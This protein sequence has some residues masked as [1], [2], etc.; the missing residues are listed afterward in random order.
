M[1]GMKHSIETKELMSKKHKGVILGKEFGERISKALKGRP[2]PRKGKKA[3]EIYK[4]I[5]AYRRHMEIG[6]IKIREARAKQIIP[7][8]DTK[9]EVK[10]Q[11]FL[12]EL[13]LSYVPHMM[14]YTKNFWHR[15][16][17]YVLGLNIVIE[18]DGD[19]FHKYPTGTDRDHI[20]TK[21]MTEAGVKVLRMWEKDINK[22]TVDNFKNILNEV[23]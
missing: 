7:Y 15:C 3:E 8:R 11:T 17:A 12:K 23:K 14:I 21:E 13:N 19:Y 10:I 5:E 1:K 4:D 16:D 18:C 6:K 2:S 9:I 22:M 20:L